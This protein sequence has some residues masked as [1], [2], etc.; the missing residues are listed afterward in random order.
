M[1]AALLWAGWAGVMLLHLGAAL[2]VLVSA[3]GFWIDGPRWKAVL[4]AAGITALVCW[5]IELWGER[6]GRQ[7]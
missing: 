6:P 4:C 1:R 2:V 7:P 3:V 5:I